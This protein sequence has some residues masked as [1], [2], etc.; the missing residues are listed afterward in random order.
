MTL[1]DLKKKQAE[2]KIKSIGDMA[3][4][5]IK[6]VPLINKML[7]EMAAESRLEGKGDKIKLW[8]TQNIFDWCKE[9]DCQAIAEYKFHPKRKWRFDFALFRK[10][11]D[12]LCA[13][14][15][16]GLNSCKSRHTTITG[17]TG[18]TEKYNAAQLEGWKVLRYTALN[19]K[20]VLIDLNKIICHHD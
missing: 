7:K 15:Y 6:D 16:E 3:D 1:K 14:E 5:Y 2:G 4:M 12:K 19:Y 11:G 9:N 13:I 8:L 17:Y 10:N 18:D 20:N